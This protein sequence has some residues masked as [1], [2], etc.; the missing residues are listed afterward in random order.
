MGDRVIIARR[1]SST[2]AL[3]AATLEV[4]RRSKVERIPLTDLRSLRF[5]SGI[6]TS[7]VIETGSGEHVIPSGAFVT[8]LR[9]IDERIRGATSHDRWPDPFANIPVIGRW[10]PVTSTRLITILIG[11]LLAAAPLLIAVFGG[12][13][14]L[15]AL[16]PI[17]FLGG[18][19]LIAAGILYRGSVTLD[20]RGL[21]VVRGS[22]TSFVAWSELDLG[23]LELRE[24]ILS[25][26]L[27]VR[28]MKH[29]R[30]ARL[31]LKT[32]LGIG[33]PVAEISGAIEI[34]A[35]KYR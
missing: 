7:L 20:E 18:L 9:H 15:L 8:E 1:G 10:V 22:S 14:K 33:F 13:L 25:K 27:A 23:L 5:V 28:T 12:P 17:T 24:E 35:V 2:V 3:D 6:G 19:S 31:A 29:G 4:R 32:V 11:S 26:T 30:P 21:F 34:A 16:M